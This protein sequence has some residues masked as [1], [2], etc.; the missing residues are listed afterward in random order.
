MDDLFDMEVHV[1][2]RTEHRGP[3]TRR[4][5]RG[6]PGGT[7]AAAA[8]EKQNN[9][10]LINSLSHILFTDVMRAYLRN[11]VLNSGLRTN[12]Q[13][14]I[15]LKRECWLVMCGWRLYPQALRMIRGSGNKK[16]MHSDYLRVGG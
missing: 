9:D 15:T 16:K 14:S 13:H 4:G 2:R 10:T 12:L 11:E 6:A 7:L 3:R 1:D 5:C 8:G